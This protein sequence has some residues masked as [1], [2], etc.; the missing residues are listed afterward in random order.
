MNALGIDIG[1]TN[2]NLSLLDLETGRVLQRRSAPNRRLNSPDEFAYLQDPELIAAG[3]RDMVASLGAPYHSVCVTGQVHGIL[4]ADEAGRAVSPLMTWLDRRGTAPLDAS[5]ATAQSRLAER[6]GVTLPSGYGLLSHYANR[7][8]GRVPAEARRILGITEYVTGAL[9]GAPPTATDASCLHPFG[10]FDPRK[11]AHVGPIP[12]EVLPPGSPAFLSPA[13]PFSPAGLSSGGIGPAG[14][15]VAHPVGDNQAGFFGLVPRPADTCLVSIGTSG[16][17]S[18]F[19]SSPE[20]GGGLELRP[21]FGLGFLHVG[22]TLCAGKTYEV[23]ETF[24]R[25]VLRAAGAEPEN[26][27]AVYRLM[28]AAAEAVPSPSPLRIDAALNGTRADPSRR[29]SIG[30]LGLDNWTLGNLV[31]GTVEGIV[32]ELA[33]FRSGAEGLF[34]PLRNVVAGGSAVQKNVL[35]RRALERGLGLELRLPRVDGAAALGAALAGAVS[36]DLL[37]LSHVEALIGAVR[38]V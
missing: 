28:A 15:P 24:L 7:L 9:T 29:G 37:P 2:L 19:S 26:R 34:A 12:D 11:N 32:S 17:I 35:F 23:L 5:G 20:G 21:Y 31:L 18:V 14:V 3:V 27:E 36:A 13:K 22:A 33:E 8:M 10:A 30:G 4:Y 6:T 16:Q 25:E 1:T 38:E